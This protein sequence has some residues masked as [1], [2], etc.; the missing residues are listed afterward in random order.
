[1]Q[2]IF[3]NC[4]QRTYSKQYLQKI[5]REFIANNSY[6]LLS[7]NSLQTKVKLLS[8]NLFQTILTN[9]YQRTHSKQYLKT[10]IRVLVVNSTYKLLSRN[11]LQSI[12]TYN[13]QRIHCKQYL[14][15]IIIEFIANYNQITHFKQ[16][17]QTIITEF[18][19]GNTYKLL[20]EN[21]L[22]PGCINYYR[23]TPSK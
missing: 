8:E 11:S 20:S 19:L 23:R 9:Y 6:N 18:I 5:I 3:T 15:T 2:A 1:M 21:S 4:Y 13:Y 22:Q 12:L 7:E 14:Q 16:Y 17:L 10:I